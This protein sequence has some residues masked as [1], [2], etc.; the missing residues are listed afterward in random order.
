[1]A[2][3]SKQDL[4]FLEHFEP[5]VFWQKYGRKILWG[6]GAVV[7]AG[8]VV[9]YQ[10]RQAAEREQQAALRLAQATDP[11]N[12]QAI[13]NEFPKQAIGAQ[14]LMQLGNVH[15]ESGRLAEAAAAYQELIRRYPSNPLADAAR[16]SAVAVLEAQGSFE[17]ALSQYLQL[18]AQPGSPLAISAKLG[19]G[20]CAEALGQ[21][22]QA[23]QIYE[24]LALV[25]QGTG[26]ETEVFVRR[27]VVMRN[28]GTLPATSGAETPVVP[29]AP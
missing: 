18:A 11:I 24:E 17:A 9:I 15:F 20:R 3:T 21:F 25:T 14:A 22:K 10:Q 12:L 23:Q 16:L 6:V 2:A 27:A 26:W 19:A 1:M 4:D 5:D 29:A 8:I 7:V 13:A 28:L